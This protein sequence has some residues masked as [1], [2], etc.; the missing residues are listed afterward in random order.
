MSNE[1]QTTELFLELGDIIKINSPLN[2]DMDKTIFFIDYLDE[3][4]ATL[5][6]TETL[7]EIVLNVLNNKFT[8]ENIESI[9]L[10]SR[11]GEKGYARQNG[12]VTGAWITIQLGGKVP[13]I[14]NGEITDLDEDMIELTTYDDKK[15][16]LFYPYPYLMA[17]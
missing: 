14:I 4:R 11:P 12:L 2:K 5:I 9:E 10:L 1:K 15:K 8:D 6:N 13:I 17:N 3:N 16:I 7:Q